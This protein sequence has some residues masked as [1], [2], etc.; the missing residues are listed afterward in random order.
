MKRKN[1][2]SDLRA[3][4]IATEIDSLEKSLIDKANLTM[5]CSNLVETT[6]DWDPNGQSQFC[7][8]V[9]N[10]EDSKSKGKSKASTKHNHLWLLITDANQVVPV[11]DEI[12]EH[13]F[14]IPPG[15]SQS[16]NLQYL[17][18]NSNICYFGFDME[19]RG[20][21]VDLNFI[22]ANVYLVNSEVMAYLNDTSK[23][24]SHHKLHS[25]LCSISDFTEIQPKQN[26]SPSL[27]TPLVNFKWDLWDWQS[28][29]V[30]FIRRIENNRDQQVVQVPIS[31]INPKADI[32][33]GQSRVFFENSGWARFMIDDDS[34]ETTNIELDVRGGIICDPPSTGKSISIIAAIWAQKLSTE[35]PR[36]FFNQD[37]SAVEQRF[38]FQSNATLIIC[39]GRLVKQWE[40]YFSQCL[41]DRCIQ[42]RIPKVQKKKKLVVSSIFTMRDYSKLSL[43]DML[44][45]DVFIVPQS[46]LRSK[47]YLRRHIEAQGYIGNSK[48]NE[49]VWFNNWNEPSTLKT[50]NL[51]VK[52]RSLLSETVTSKD[53]YGVPLEGIF[54]SRIIVDEAHELVLKQNYN[55]VAPYLCIRANH[56]WLLTATPNF[57]LNN[58]SSSSSKRVQ[59]VEVNLLDL[60]PINI[61]QS[62]KI[63]KDE[64]LD[65][66]RNK[67]LV[68]TVV[69][70]WCRR[71]GAIAKRPM[72]EHFVEIVLNPL[73]QAIYH[74]SSGGTKRL[75]QFCSYHTDLKSSDASTGMTVEEAASTIDSERN[76]HL[77]ELQSQKNALIVKLECNWDMFLDWLEHRPA[78]E[79]RAY[80]EWKSTSQLPLSERRTALLFYLESTNFFSGDLQSEHYKMSAIRDFTSKIVQLN[81]QLNIKSREKIY[82]D[83]VLGLLSNQAPLSC[84]IHYGDIPLGRTMLLSCG[85]Y[86]CEPCLE[87]CWKVSAF[88]NAGKTCPSCRHPISSAK[89]IR[90]IDRRVQLSPT[91]IETSLNERFG[92]KIS[93]L[94]D[95]ISQIKNDPEQGK[96]LVFAKWDELLKQIEGALNTLEIKTARPSGNIHKIKSEFSRFYSDDDTS[97][98][99]LSTQNNLSGSHLVNANNLI[100]VHP[101]DDEPGDAIKQWEQAISRMQ[102]HGQTRDLRVWY[103]VSQNTVETELTERFKAYK[104][105][106]QN[107]EKLQ[108]QAQI[109]SEAA[110]TEINVE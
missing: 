9:R 90:N 66:H 18:S 64:D 79:Q 38:Y 84:P 105:Q 82:F 48:P 24:E 37:L 71:S 34:K 42:D 3:D 99:L 47:S 22:R 63:L 68:N 50:Q 58:N 39:P 32:R 59:R 1:S 29:N 110:L 43:R 13:L 17:T 2:K 93:K 83:S 19:A 70:G 77:Q 52:L 35:T 55:M 97:V 53:I 86:F 12:I 95:V 80:H 11:A 107:K 44:N 7:R 45:V 108:Q 76:A 69:Q 91:I 72:T 15:N 33:I 61:K 51:I 98:L 81:K 16:A 85:H 89:D 36:D 23:K 62:K 56:H 25:L 57:E 109:Q 100:F 94:V 102:R 4:Y 20:S 46:L 92:T 31:S 10:P 8:L 103:L 87:E 21:S 104:E 6:F 101:F 41:G 40:G 26:I 14:N 73:E 75:L 65:I 49:N 67:Y 74:S 60:I 78:E 54:W 88:T 106:F 5:I 28:R 30:N 27:G 96:I